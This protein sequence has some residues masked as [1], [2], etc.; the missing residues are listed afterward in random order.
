MNPYRQDPIWCS[1]QAVRDAAAQL[2]HGLMWSPKHDLRVLAWRALRAY[3]GAR[4]R[5]GRL[6]RLYLWFEAHNRRKHED[7]LLLSCPVACEE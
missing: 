3:Y 6:P 7:A 2:Q 1:A 4:V 5:G